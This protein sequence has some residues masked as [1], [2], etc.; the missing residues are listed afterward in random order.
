MAFDFQFKDGHLISPNGGMITIDK[1]SFSGYDKMSND[2]QNSKFMALRGLKRNGTFTSK[3]GKAQVHTNIF[4]DL[5]TTKEQ[6]VFL[7]FSL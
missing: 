4:K 5:K 3:N 2:S 7:S 6:K 1:G